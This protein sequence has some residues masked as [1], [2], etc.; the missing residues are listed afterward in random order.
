[1]IRL[2]DKNVWIAEQCELSSQ[3]LCDYFKEYASNVNGY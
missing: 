3:F 1:M 2:C